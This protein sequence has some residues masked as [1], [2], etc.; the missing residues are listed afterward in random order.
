MRADLW[1]NPASSGRGLVLAQA[2]A[3]R[4][5]KWLFFV[6]FPFLA[7]CSRVQRTL[8]GSVWSVS[9][10]EW[11][12]LEQAT[13]RGERHSASFLLTFQHLMKKLFKRREL[14]REGPYCRCPEAVQVV[15]CCVCFVQLQPLPR[16]CTSCILLCLLCPVT[17]L[18]V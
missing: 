3:R 17:H 4:R 16:G 1:P 14:D 5:E 15:F 8:N 2:C 12:G 18:V 9:S 13:E 7:V 11:A 6:Y 10:G